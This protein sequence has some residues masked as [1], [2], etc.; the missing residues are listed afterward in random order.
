LWGIPFSILEAVAWHH[1]PRECKDKKFS[2]LTAVHVANVAEHRR[3]QVDENKAI[4]TLDELYLNEIGVWDEAQEW[5]KFRPDRA[6][7][8]LPLKPYIVQPAVAVAKGAKRI[9]SWVWII[10][11]MLAGVAAML[12]AIALFS[13]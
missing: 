9:P 12:A 1:Y 10:L 13:K 8:E 5:V 2:A 11:S 4:P 6:A 7:S 3:Q